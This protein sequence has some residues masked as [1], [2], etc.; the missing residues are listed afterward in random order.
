[1]NT[2]NACVAHL[3]QHK[4]HQSHQTRRH[5]R[6]QKMHDVLVYVIAACG[7]FHSSKEL[8]AAA[9]KLVALHSHK[10]ISW[11]MVFRRNI[12]V[13]VEIYCCEITKL[14]DPFWRWSEGVL[15]RG[16]RKMPLMIGQ[17][18]L[19]VPHVSDQRSDEV[20][21][22][23][24]RYWEIIQAQKLKFFLWT[25]GNENLVCASTRSQRAWFSTP[26]SFQFVLL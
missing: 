9:R 16:L 14:R 22:F 4:Q 13:V 24:N 1:V 6:Q 18:S 10:S 15:V 7:T 21:G 12:F 3:K 2:T 20:A 17:N 25:Q 11:P 8:L 26:A 19:R 23:R 5:R